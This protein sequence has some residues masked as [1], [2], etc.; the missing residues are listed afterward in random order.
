MSEWIDHLNYLLLAIAIGINGYHLLLI[1]RYVDDQ[2][3]HIHRIFNR[4]TGEDGAD[5][6]GKQYKKIP[7]SSDMKF[8]DK[9]SDRSSKDSLPDRGFEG[10]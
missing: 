10:L 7:L 8:E 6:V 2:V 5:S 1:R 9:T 4:M 3:N